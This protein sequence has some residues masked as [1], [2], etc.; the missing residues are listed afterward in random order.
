MD[1]IVHYFQRLANV[2]NDE[3]EKQRAAKCIDALLR[4]ARRSIGLELLSLSSPAGVDVSDSE[5]KGVEEQELLNKA[6]QDCHRLTQSASRDSIRRNDLREA[7]R[8]IQ[9]A[10]EQKGSGN[11]QSRCYLLALACRII[12]LKLS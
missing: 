9:E 10:K 11:L 6:I 3:K 2:S 1:P 12:A 5:E 8:H 7:M 4:T